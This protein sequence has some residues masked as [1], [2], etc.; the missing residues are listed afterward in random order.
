MTAHRWRLVRSEGRLTVDVDDPRTFSSADV[1]ALV[2]AVEPELDDHVTE[3]YL[4]GEAMV[5]ERPTPDHVRM[6]RR[7]GLLVNRHRKA[8]TLHL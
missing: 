8:F 5:T 6:I 7:V 4:D 2:E 3:V 1:D